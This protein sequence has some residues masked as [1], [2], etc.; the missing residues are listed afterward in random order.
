MP[1]QKNTLSVWLDAFARL[2]A[3]FQRLQ[4]DRWLELHEVPR[5]YTGGDV[6]LVSSPQ[7]RG[8]AVGLYVLVG[9]LESVTLTGTRLEF[10]KCSRFKRPI[11][12][13]YRDEGI[14]FR[15]HDLVADKKEW[16]NFMY[17]PANAG[18][19]VSAQVKAEQKLDALL[20]NRPSTREEDM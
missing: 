20:E 1:E 5:H 19:I 2:D 14:D 17:L 10:E 6:L 15:R 12:V 16:V 9:V 7:G 4:A 8:E 11:V 18:E 13:I 3:A